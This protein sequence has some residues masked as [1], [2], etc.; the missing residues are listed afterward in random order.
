MKTV[1]Q[2]VQADCDK[3]M[4]NHRVNFPNARKREFIYHSTVICEVDDY[5][6]TFKLSN[7]GYW[8]NSTARALSAYRN[9]FKY[10]HTEILELEIIRK[11]RNGLWVAVDQI[12][13]EWEL[14]PE[15]HSLVTFEKGNKYEAISRNGNISLALDIKEAVTV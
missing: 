14:D 1:E 9:E 12:G 8:T 3:R 2:L 15:E 7:G 4:G 6:R 11:K 10:S 13:K 5:D